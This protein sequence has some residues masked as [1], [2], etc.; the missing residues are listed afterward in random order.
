MGCSY[1][2]NEFLKRVHIFEGLA[3]HSSGVMGRGC[4]GVAKV[5]TLRI[6][7]KLRF[8]FL[9][10][11]INAQVLC[12]HRSKRPQTTLALVSDLPSSSLP[13][14][15][16]HRIIFEPCLRIIREHSMKSVPIG[17]SGKSGGCDERLKRE[18]CAVS[19]N[20]QICK[21]APFVVD[22]PPLPPSDLP[23]WRSGGP[24]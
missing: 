13:F 10:A 22:L 2:Q 3:V 18:V 11:E 8:F 14:S 16:R 4:V 15:R 24:K 7:G 21:P 17:F 19:A 5:G 20:E 9:S 1:C 12:I 6:G 23:R